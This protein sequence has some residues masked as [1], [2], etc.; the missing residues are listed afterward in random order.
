MIIHLKSIYL[1]HQEKI[2]D[3]NTTIT[4][5]LITLFTTTYEQNRTNSCRIRKNGLKQ[6]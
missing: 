2:K 3:K 1:H 4:N 6:S 5:I